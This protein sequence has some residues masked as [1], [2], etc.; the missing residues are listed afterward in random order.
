MVKLLYCIYKKNQGR[1]Q[2]VIRAITGFLF[3]LLT[4]DIL[5]RFENFLDTLISLF[6]IGVLRRWV[7]Y[8]L[9]LLVKN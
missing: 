5:L 6:I 1:K 4:I 3:G 7:A 8:R 9:S 2:Q